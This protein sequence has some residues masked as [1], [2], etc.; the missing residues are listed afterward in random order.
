MDRDV[1]DI[2]CS[3]IPN[4]SPSI[5]CDNQEVARRL[6]RVVSFDRTTDRR[7]LVKEKD[8]TVDG[9]EQCWLELLRERPDTEDQT[10][11]NAWMDKVISYSEE[12]KGQ[13]DKCSTPVPMQTTPCLNTEPSQ[14][15]GRL[16]S[17]TPSPIA[18]PPTTTNQTSIDSRVPASKEF[19]APTQPA[20][21]SELEYA[22][23]V[24]NALR[25]SLNE[26][27]VKLAAGMGD[28]D[29]S[30]LFDDHDYKKG[31]QI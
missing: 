7:K 19:K 6:Q 27:E 23:M 13:S 25:E 15:F 16:F 24:C 31:V 3:V 9:N 12:M 20:C 2:Y 17:E 26:E 30:A 4:S 8:M 5:S 22:D 21:Q 18:V 29:F 11:M 1:D 10:R 14:I 28:F